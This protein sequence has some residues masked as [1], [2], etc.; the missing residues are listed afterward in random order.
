MRVPQQTLDMALM[1]SRLMATGSG[2]SWTPGITCFTFYLFYL[3]LVIILTRV[4]GSDPS[5]S[6]RIHLIY[7]IRM[8]TQ[9]LKPGLRV[10]IDLMQICIRI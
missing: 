3:F 4:A 2:G 6:L 7:R 5:G 1:A 10:R 8:R 9:V